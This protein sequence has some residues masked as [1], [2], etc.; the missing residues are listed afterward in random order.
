MEGFKNNLDPTVLDSRAGIVPRSVHH[1]FNTLEKNQAE[2]TIKVTCLE[3]Y[4][5]ELQ[6][7]LALEKRQL[8]IFDESAGRKGTLVSGLEEVV[9]TDS[10]QILS[11]LDTAQKRRQQAETQM[12]KNSSRSHVITTI[13]VHLKETTMEGEELIKTGKLN[14]VDLAGSENISRSGAQNKRAKEAG[15]INQSLLTL[16]RVITALTEH[17]PHIPYRESKLTRLLQ[18]SLGGKTRTCIVATISPSILNIEETLSTLEYSMRAKSI[19]NKP[20]LNM[21]VSKQAMINVLNTD[22]DKL[23]LELQNQR[24]KNGVYMSPEQYQ[25]INLQIQ[26][27]TQQIADQQDK[28]KVLKED[29]TEITRQLLE[30]KAALESEIVN[31]NSTRTTLATT[32]TKLA[33]TEAELVETQIEVKE[34][35]YV[36]D[37]HERVET[38]L[39]GQATTTVDN[40]RESYRETELLEG[41][42]DRKS[43]LEAENLQQVEQ[44]QLEMNRNIA[45]AE[46]NMGE[47]QET[48]G[49]IQEGMKQT[50]NSFVQSKN[51]SIDSVQS[52]LTQLQTTFNETS[53]K[54]NELVTQRS[55]QSSE[56][57]S[58]VSNKH[59]EHSQAIVDNLSRLQDMF[60]KS[61][62]GLQE[63][64]RVY[65]TELTDMNGFIGTC[66]AKHTHAVN[67]FMMDHGKLMRNLRD[68]VAKSSEAQVVAL[69]TYQTNFHEMIEQTRKDNVQMKDTF[70]RSVET[71]LEDNLKRQERGLDERVVDIN[72]FV[73]SAVTDV[74]SFRSHVNTNTSNASIRV[75]ALGQTLIATS[76]EMGST[77][78]SVIN[79]MKNAMVK[80]GEN[81][82]AMTGLV[83]GNSTKLVQETKDH[84]QFVNKNLTLERDQLS[85]FKD[86]FGSTTRDRNLMINNQQ[87]GLVQQVN[88]FDQVV[89][90]GFVTGNHE[91]ISNISRQV[92]SFTSGV[93][94]H[95][96]TVRSYLNGFVGGYKL[97]K[98]TGST[99]KKRKRDAETELTRTRPYDELRTEFR[100]TLTDINKE[101]MAG[102]LNVQ[103]IAGLTINVENIKVEPRS[104]TPTECSPLTT[105][106]PKKLLFSSTPTKDTKKRRKMGPSSIGNVPQNGSRLKRTNSNSNFGQFR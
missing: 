69:Q 59:S 26:N 63:Q 44:F 101:N 93:G 12:N 39:Y 11:V 41:K 4:N 13:T 32:Q 53:N 100:V 38:V 49:T 6:D 61:V 88:V 34:K 1:I 36:I 8:R 25:E 24:N 2:Y 40:L 10:S 65:Q 86:R 28:Y 52:N 51:K 27:L 84:A 35:Q 85:A 90:D 31:H 94:E 17:T 58:L 77:T 50:I 67:D 76:E 3:L 9:V 19:K 99:P 83:M 71:L 97:D 37:E 78:G 46:G 42:V 30:K 48:Y 95:H 66:I 70:M 20:E 72:R 47:F 16:G 73:D 91:G 105:T 29:N 5:E 56:N 81:V 21:K 14:L 43:Q 92:S 103:P 33:Q 7:L 60:A 96:H 45:T 74:H 68:N 80:T 102:G 62:N 75:D 79:G 89:L 55:T 22:I 87:Q 54:I 106:S 18:D 57:V 104:A 82:D 98:S 23:R 64:L 15:M